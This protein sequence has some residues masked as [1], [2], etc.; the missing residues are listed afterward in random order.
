MT[1]RVWNYVLSNGLTILDT[2]SASLYLTRKGFE[3]WDYASAISSAFSLGVKST[4]PGS[5]FG[6][7]AAS[8]VNGRKVTSIAINDGIITSAGIATGYAIVSTSQLFA[9]GYLTQET[10]FSST[11]GVFTLPA[12]TITLPAST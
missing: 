8:T 5:L 10:T 11:V 4:T 3:P 1:A 12:F 7:P 6:A 2:T 9:T